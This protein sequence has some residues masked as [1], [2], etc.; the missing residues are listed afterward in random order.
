MKYVV[1]IQM[2]INAASDANYVFSMNDIFDPD[3]SGIGTTVYYMSQSATQWKK[4]SVSKSKLIVQG[5]GG[6]VDMDN[7]V[8]IGAA[9]LVCA[10]YPN[11][12]AAGST[13]LAAGQVQIVPNVRRKVIYPTCIQSSFAAAA[14][15]GYA[16]GRIK[17]T[18]RQ[19]VRKM[20]TIYDPSA[21]VGTT[22]GSG[23]GGSSPPNPLYWIF[24]AHN[25]S[26]SHP[27]HVYARCSLIYWVTLHDRNNVSAG[28]LP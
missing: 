12:L 24:N 5:M 13:P 11:P 22:G 10:I 18:N 3:V 15:S 14:G 6:N 25:T 19:T 20:Y 17:M 23:S 28:A 4:Y 1:D 16:M 7:I 21:N 2:T 27:S 9:P 26:T 8:N